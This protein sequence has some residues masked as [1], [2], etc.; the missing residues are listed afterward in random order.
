MIS[1]ILNYRGYLLDDNQKFY[2][3]TRGTISATALI[4]PLGD[5]E[6]SKSDT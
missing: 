1:V 4:A 3:K 2:Y 6:M 5:G